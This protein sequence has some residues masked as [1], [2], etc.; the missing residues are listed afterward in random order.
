M[1]LKIIN[2]LSFIALFVVCSTWMAPSGGQSGNYAGAPGDGGAQFNNTCSQSNGGCHRPGNGTFSGSV[3]LLGLPATYNPGSTYN[4]TLRLDDSGNSSSIEG[5]FQIVATENGDNN[6][7]YGT[8]TR[9]VGESRLAGSG[10][11]IQST[12]KLMM[13]GV[14]EWTFDYTVPAATGTA[15]PPNIVFYYVG[16][17]VNGGGTGNDYVYDNI[18]ATALPI[19]L[20]G[21]QVKPNEKNQAVLNWVTA[22]EINSD[23][24]LIERSQNGIDFESIGEIEA[25]GSS[26]DNLNY[27]FV[28]ISPNSGLNYYRLKQLDLDESF[29]Y[30]TIKSLDLKEAKTALSIYPNPSS[31]ELRVN[32]MGAGIRKASVVNSMGQMIKEFLLQ[33]GENV[34]SVNDLSKGIYFL[35]Y[36][37]GNSIAM[38]QFVKM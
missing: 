2:Y 23:K 7:Q 37:N 22:L 19:E 34:I 35:Q 12:P 6:V 10:R 13:N 1:K 36:E 16:N 17:A 29:E 30:S 3:D 20:V 27:Q 11:L 24:F 5:G 32:N 21:F 25:A 26:F 15:N 31:K 28:D 4:L 38:E 8:F 14:V 9:V 33:D 18:S